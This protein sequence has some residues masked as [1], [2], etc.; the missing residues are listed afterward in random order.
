MVLLTPEEQWK[1]LEEGIARAK[2]AV[3]E[4]EV[5]VCLYPQIML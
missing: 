4:A 1:L 3:F 2:D 5:Q